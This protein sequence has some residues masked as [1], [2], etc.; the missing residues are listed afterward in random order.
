[1]KRSEEG[2]AGVDARNATYCLCKSREFG[3]DYRGVH[4]DISDG[5][6]V[7]SVCL[8]AGQRDGTSG[9]PLS[10]LYFGRAA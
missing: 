5:T 10:D 1:M 4:G 3:A 8:C 9:T 6:Y 2:E 7:S